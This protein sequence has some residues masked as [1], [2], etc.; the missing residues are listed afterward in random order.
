MPA[1]YHWNHQIKSWPP[2]MSGPS[3][4]VVSNLTVQ[5]GQSLQ[6]VMCWGG[7]VLQGLTTVSGSDWIMPLYA[8]FLVE[9]H[10]EG[11]PVQQLH[12]RW[13]AMEAVPTIPSTPDSGSTYI[14]W[15]LP[16]S[17]WE[18]DVTA[19]A[20][21]PNGQTYVLVTWYVG[22]MVGRSTTQGPTYINGS[23]TLKTLTSS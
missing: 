12:Q 4:Q 6:R 8:R 13:Q 3:W 7:V 16:S 2:A 15:V 14:S 1:V 18:L 19:R 10:A 5:T 9:L 17:F 11:R 21:S 23:V 22:S 20:E